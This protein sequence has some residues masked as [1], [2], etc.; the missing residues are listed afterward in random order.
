MGKERS[1]SLKNKEDLKKLNS[2]EVLF[3]AVSLI[4]YWDG[5]HEASEQ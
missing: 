5:A 2:R 3:R 1:R 4:S